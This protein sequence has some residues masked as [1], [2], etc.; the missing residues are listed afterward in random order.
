[1]KK[2]LFLLLLVPVVSC[3]GDDEPTETTS[4]IFLEKYNNTIWEENTEFYYKNVADIKFS[5]SEYFISFF[6][7]FSQSSYCWGWKEGE[8][9]YSGVK[10]EIEIIRDDEYSLQFRV[11]HYKNI[12]NEISEDIEYSVTH[13][14]NLDNGILYYFK[15]ES[16]TSS[17]TVGRIS[18]LPS[19]RNYSES[20]LDTGGIQKNTGCMF[21]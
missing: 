8:N 5:N 7:I 19:K 9:T 18:Y 12:Y 3:S 6:D 20:S 10:L 4:G 21:Y 2:L 1:M 13:E 14:Y 17:V 15:S 16:S 11:D